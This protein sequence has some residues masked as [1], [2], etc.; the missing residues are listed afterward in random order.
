MVS[1]VVGSVVYCDLAL[2][3]EHS[4]IYVGENQIVHLDGDGDI[5]IVSP[6]DFLA[7]LDGFN[8][9]MSSYSK[10]TPYIWH[11]VNNGMTRHPKHHSG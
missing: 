9:A 11:Y 2:T 5:Q 7:R 3:T 8:L 6:D 4:G 10:P 1:P